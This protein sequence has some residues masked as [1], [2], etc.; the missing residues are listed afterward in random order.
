VESACNLY[1]ADGILAGK[2][3]PYVI[4]EVPGQENMKFQTDV[5]K[6]TL[7]PVWNFTGEID[8][9]MDG[10][11]LQFTVMDKDTW[12]KPDDLLGKVALTAADFYPQGF[13][14]EIPL[15]E[16]KAANAT[17]TVMISVAG[18]NEPGTAIVEEGGGVVEIAC[19]GEQEAV[20][21]QLV[22]GGETHMFT[23]PG[24]MV[25]TSGEQVMT[26]PYSPRTLTMAGA[27]STYTAV[28][29]PGQP[30]YSGSPITYSSCPTTQS[31]TYSAPQSVS[32]PM[33][34]SA[35]GSAPG[36][37]VTQVIV[38]A[39][40]T[41]TAEEFAQT[42]GTIVSTPLPVTVTT[43]AIETGIVETSERAIEKPIKRLKKKSRGCC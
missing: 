10:D 13:A 18:S 39:P 5:M 11:V 15:S 38:H 8:G 37:K 31:I 26:G 14:A 40:V 42:N 32:M 23:A 16:S 7:N 4:V 41:V 6:N 25:T 28:G 9:F 17:L 20:E 12:P 19:A 2:S 36:S 43:D 24:T 21:G 1:N 33:T 27:T 29:V 34:Y 22:T 35:P 3:D 30:Y